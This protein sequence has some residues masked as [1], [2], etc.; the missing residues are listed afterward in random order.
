MP[1]PTLRSC[2]VPFPTRPLR[3]GPRAGALWRQGRCTVG[4]VPFGI[5]GCP[6]FGS[7]GR[8]GVLPANR[9]EW[10]PHGPMSGIRPAVRGELPSAL[11][12]AGC[13]GTAALW[14]AG[15]VL[16]TWLVHCGVGAVPVSRGTLAASTLGCAPCAPP[17]TAAGWPAPLVALGS[18]GRAVRS[19]TCVGPCPWPGVHF[20]PGPPGYAFP[21]GPRVALAASV[22]GQTAQPT[23]VLRAL[24]TSTCGC[25]GSARA[26][27]ASFSLGLSLL[28]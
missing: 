20:L 5:P 26:S 11:L 27:T 18:L 12:D 25:A 21:P 1:L 7:S 2:A 23:G 3:W 15:C 9:R 22:Y 24:A 14:R 8:S 19:D 17:L 13:G 10:S 28:V 16:D 6:S 4:W